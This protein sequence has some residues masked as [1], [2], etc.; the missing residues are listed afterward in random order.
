MSKSKTKVKTSTDDRTRKMLK[1]LRRERDEA[2]R[3]A[4]IAQESADLNHRVWLPRTRGQ[5]AHANGWNCFRKAAKKK[6]TRKPR[7]GADQRGW[8]SEPQATP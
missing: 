7:S 5:I 4:C 8:G 2:R 1:R 3:W 6:D